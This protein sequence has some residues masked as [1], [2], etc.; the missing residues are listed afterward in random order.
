MNLY[1]RINNEL[2]LCYPLISNTIN[3]LEYRN[4]CDI[5]LCLVKKGKRSLVMI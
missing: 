3:E 2:K 5:S 4:V 1:Y